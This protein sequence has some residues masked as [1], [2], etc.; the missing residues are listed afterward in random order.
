MVFLFQNCHQD[1]STI[2]E[3]DQISTEL[4]S[5]PSKSNSKVDVRHYNEDTND[6]HMI[7]ISINAVPAHLGHGDIIIDEVEIFNRALTPPEI[8]DIYAGNCKPCKL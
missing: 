3:E 8:H 1:D 4:S 5:K 2:S 6:W 7:S